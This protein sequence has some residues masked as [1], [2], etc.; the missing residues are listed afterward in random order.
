M[1]LF[2][3]YKHDQPLLLSKWFTHR[4]IILAKGQLGHLYTFLK[5]FSNPSSKRIKPGKMRSRQSFSSA[6]SS[7][8]KK[9][10]SRLNNDHII[11][12][13]YCKCYYPRR[14]TVLDFTLWYLFQS[15]FL[16]QAPKESSRGK[17]RHANRFHQLVHQCK[18]KFDQGSI[19]ITRFVTVVTGEKKT[20][21][22]SLPN[23]HL[24]STLR[25]IKQSWVGSLSCW[26]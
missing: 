5:Q 6:R 8:Q 24:V 11:I 1:A 4:G 22:L 26:L 3:K 17:C 25:F 12:M 16:T 20:L 9:I 19:M 21:K 13:P 23:I 2:K 10:W 7:M 15:N 14:P 18:K